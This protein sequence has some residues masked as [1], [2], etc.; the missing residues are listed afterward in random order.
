V[1]IRLIGYIAEVF[2]YREKTV[3]IEKPVRI[4][5]LFSFPNNM[6]KERLI[7]LINGTPATLKSKVLDKDEIMI[8]QMVGGG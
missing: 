8:M 6:D 7:I 2:G 3:N 4:E 5:E 1:K